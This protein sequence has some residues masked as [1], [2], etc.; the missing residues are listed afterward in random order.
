MTNQA[1]LYPGALLIAL[2]AAVTAT[3][4][5]AMQILVPALPTL[6]SAFAVDA[7][8]VQLTLSL[9]L[10]AIAVATLVYGPLSDRF[11]RRPV[12]LWGMA[13]FVLGTA[14]SMVAPDI[15]WLIFGRLVQAAGGAA[16]MVLAR[17]I[18]RDLWHAD[19]AA[20][21]IAKLTMVMVVAPMV[22]P[23]IGGTLT[24]LSGWRAVFWFSGVAGLVIGLWALLQ[25]PESRPAS[26]P[27]D[28]MRGMLRGFAH[29]LRSGRFCGY[30]G[31]T[32]FSS[33]IFFSF[34][35]GAPYIM[36]DILERPAAEYGLWFIGAS[37]GFMLGNFLAI[38]SSGRWSLQA[39][40]LAGSLFSLAGV[41]ITVTLILT[42][43]LSPLA[44]FGPVT[45][46]M[47]G[48]GLA[49]PNA[50]AGA[51]NVFPHRAGTASGFSGFAQMT[52]SA[53][54]IQSVGQLYDGTPFPMLVF[55]LMGAAGA[56]GSILLVGVLE[57]RHRQ[58]HP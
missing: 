19:A 55:M 39:L 36:V 23:A 8:T 31:H 10:V 6:Q 12:L 35:S 34:I 37:L 48:N 24:D 30:V 18:V 22:A 13:L 49:M 43:G 51:L 28:G 2:L 27:V 11:G 40:M 32:A 38:R 3:G 56:L 7:G 58:T 5:L 20:A 4:P 46:S 21:V 53:V 16:G 42:V 33:M 52:L 14:I 45:L 25:L 15:E 54:A 57:R 44:L 1:S 9:S 50:Q 17:A 29:L 47:L 26:T 41:L